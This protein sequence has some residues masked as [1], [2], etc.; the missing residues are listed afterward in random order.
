MPSNLPKPS[1]LAALLAA[2]S[3][4]APDCGCGCP[5][6]PGVM[7]GCDCTTCV[8]RRALAALAPALAEEVLRLR[9]ALPKAIRSAKIEGYALSL[10]ADKH[11]QPRCKFCT[12]FWDEIM[13]QARAALELYA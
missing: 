11:H 10:H 6:E 8:A 4:A 5:G 9:E 3:K 1:D 13:D 7:P 12:E 2:A